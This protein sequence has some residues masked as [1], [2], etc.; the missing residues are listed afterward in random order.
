MNKKIFS[1]SIWMMSEKIISIFGLIFVTSYVAKY[2]G[3]G[4]F[5]QISFSMSLF[6]IVQVIAQLGSSIV[7]F[8]RIS[9]NKRS[10]IILINTTVLMR[11]FFYF[12]CSFPIVIYFFIHGAND[13]FW[14]IFAAFLSCFFSS[15]DVYSVYYDAILKSKINTVI[16]V[17]GLILSLVLRWWI[18]SFEMPPVLLTI[19]IVL[20][21]MFPY[22]LRAIAYKNNYNVRPLLKR[23]RGKYRRYLLK[24][25]G[26]FVISDVSIAI[27]TRLS[28]LILAVLESKTSVGIYS[29]ALN[30]AG[31][32]SFITMSLIT[33][34]LPSIFS[35]KNDSLALKKTV[36]LNIYMAIISI[37][38]I[39]FAYLLGGWFLRFFYGVEY[40]GAFYPLI[41]LCMSTMVST[42]GT[43]SARF[44]AKY[45]GYSFLSKKMLIVLVSSLILNYLLIAKFGILGAAISTLATEILS[46]TLY[47]Y[48]FK[49]GI[50]AS[51]HIE[52]IKYILMPFRR[53]G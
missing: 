3:P 38:V 42:L 53:R 51:L 45:S 24:V 52:T 1:N 44:I 11:A 32:W 13:S 43:V 20:T 46:L 27:Y 4:T 19:P 7:I 30:L 17:C 25:G 36:K 5:G 34:T 15:L 40:D 9:K 35:E 31:S 23:H 10:G 47:N 37:T 22:L 14:F 33:S 16:N 18:A 48:F 21:S 50:V 12:I 8:K 28:L 29:V 49:R 39:F 26:S 6:Q 2:V 41:I